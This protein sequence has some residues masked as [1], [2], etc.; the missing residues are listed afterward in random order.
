[1]SYTECVEFVYYIS[2]VQVKVNDCLYNISMDFY[3]NTC[4]IIHVPDLRTDIGKMWHHNKSLTKCI[5]EVQDMINPIEDS[6]ML[7]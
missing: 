3:A 5:K 7:D 6:V 4:I 2:G 1:M